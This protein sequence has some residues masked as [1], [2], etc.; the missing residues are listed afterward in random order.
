MAVS[1]SMSTESAS[2]PVAFE[3][4][5]PV[6]WTEELQTQADGNFG[7]L[8]L[9]LFGKTVLLNRNCYRAAFL[10]RRLDSQFHR[11]SRWRSC[12]NDRV[13]LI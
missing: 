10:R 4:Y 7:G 9:S 11:I 1:L 2:L 8:G 5:L 12:R 3:L 6:S 13:D